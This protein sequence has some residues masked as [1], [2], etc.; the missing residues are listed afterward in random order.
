MALTEEEQSERDLGT[1]FIAYIFVM[2]AYGFT[3]FQTYFYYSK[4]SKSTDGWVLRAVVGTLAVLDTA[5]SGMFSH[6]MYYYLIITYMEGTDMDVITK[7]LCATL[8]LSIVCFFIVEM[9]HCIRAW[10][11]GHP[12]TSAAIGFLGAATLALGT[13]MSVY[14]FEARDFGVLE[15]TKVKAITAAALGSSALAGMAIVYF[16][17]SDF[18]FTCTDC[19]AASSTRGLIDKI[20]MLVLRRGVM[21]AVFQLACF[22]LLLAMPWEKYWLALLFTSAKS[23]INC[24]FYLLNS[25]ESMHATSLDTTVM[26]TLTMDSNRLQWRDSMSSVPQGFQVTTSTFIPTRATSSI[27]S[28]KRRP[29]RGGDDIHDVRGPTFA[30][31]RH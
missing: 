16:Q 31:R 4:C 5:S 29:W 30:P 8:L 3:V 13:A 25:R 9:Y 15:Q 26:D 17:F 22:V 18:R 12:T 10:Q 20:N 23:H 7:P 11:E 27:P 21:P 19:S 28:T 1:M 2:M 6:A 24:F 14:L